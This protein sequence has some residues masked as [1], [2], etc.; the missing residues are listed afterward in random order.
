MDVRF[1]VGRYFDCPEGQIPLVINREELRCDDFTQRMAFA[2]IS[3]DFDPH[4]ISFPFSRT[5]TT[6]TLLVSGAGS[7]TH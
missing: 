3:V 6:S 1:I 4:R 5:G 7:F 2:A